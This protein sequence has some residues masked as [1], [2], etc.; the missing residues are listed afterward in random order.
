MKLL[1]S[2]VDEQEAQQAIKGGADIIDAKN[3]KEGPLGANFPWVIKNIRTITPKDRAVSCT[4]G[5]LPYL[6]GS[7]S[8]AAFGAA[9]LGVDYV[10]VSLLEMH[11]KA[12]AV[13]LLKCVVRAVREVGSKAFVV[14]VGYADAVRVGSVD[15]FLVPEVA[16]ESGCDFAMLDTAVKDGKTLF[17]ALTAQQLQK[18][19]DK[20]HGYGLK[21]ALAGSLKKEQLLVLCGLGVDVIGLRGAACEGE[22]RVVGRI[23]QEKVRELVKTVKAA[24]AQT[25]VSTF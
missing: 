9:S 3:P 15:P 23:T 5:D 4:L 6:P 8:L 25:V 19:V 21:V 7:V 14:A 13:D 16:W 1:V 17:D 18:F 22:D 12:E 24:C 11:M 2:P 20:A 10:K